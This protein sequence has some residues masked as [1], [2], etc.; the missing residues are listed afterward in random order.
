MPVRHD[1][2]HKG[3][4]RAFPADFVTLIAPQ[5]ASEIELDALSFQPEEHYFDGRQRRLDLVGIAPTRRDPSERVV[6]NGEVELKFLS[7][8]EPR[9]FRYNQVLERN[10]RLS[11]HSAVMYLRG[12]PPGV[13][14]Q[15]YRHTSVGLEI[16][17]FHYHCLGLSRA[18]PE[19]I[20]NRREPLAWAL[21]SLI[22]PRSRRKRAELRL[23]CLRRI[24]TA[25][26]L[27][28]ERR[29]ML[30]DCV[31]TYIELEPEVRREYE[32]LLAEHGNR[33]VREMIMTWSEKVE[34]RAHAA[35]IR[36]E[37]QTNLQKLRD[38]VSRRL[39]ERFGV[40]S[41]SVG[42]RIAQISSPDE[43]MDLL[44]RAVAANSLDDLGLAP[45]S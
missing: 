33:E 44:E 5:L 9:L 19:E 3:L 29:F 34:A 31:Q 10:H 12:G 15:V 28:E 11:A 42:D 37:R 14:R 27:D 20:L 1:Q 26:E 35:G 17:S 32:A 7:V 39:N 18:S 45:R 41:S 43:L 38:R 6:I 24:A 22:R 8:M 30:Y 2:I 23:A 13:S 25:R 36:S 16:Y 21:A 4:I 40:L